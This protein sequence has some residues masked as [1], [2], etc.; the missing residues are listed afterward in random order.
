MP[1]SIRQ[2]GAVWYARGTIRIGP[3]S[4]RISEFSTGA[5]TRAAAR[6]F[7]DEHEAKI[8]REA[9][10]GDHGR[11]SR[12]TLADCFEAYI[13][14]PGGV[15]AY[16]MERIVEF[17]ERL[18]H[19]KL[20]EAG[21][22]WAEFL[23]TRGAKMAPATASRWRAIY[24]AAIKVGAEA[25]DAP[26]PNV[27]AVRD[28]T[29]QVLRTL[30]EQERSDLLAAYGEAASPVFLTLAYQGLRT[31]EALRLDWRNVHWARS[32]SL[33]ISRSKSGKP[34]SVPM[35]T[36]VRARLY[37]LWESA[38]KPDSGPVFLSGRKAPEARGEIDPTLTQ[39]DRKAANK[40]LPNIPYADTRGKGG[41]PLR[42]AHQLACK[43]AGV[44]DFRIHDWRHDWASRMVMAGVDLFTLMKLGGW[45][46]LRMVEIYGSSTSEHM[47]SAVQKIV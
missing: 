6:S 38:G 43:K 16:D 3:E 23:S 36:K 41:N 11:R 8:R 22:A 4:I 19:R 25:N 30:T 26:I 42:S 35:H 37:L 14:R 13:G 28:K 10:E 45:S 2:R 39:R 21:N 1:L 31:S 32:G 15:P 40:A 33:Y 24:M 12:L 47:A 9:L 44:R 18:G 7:A 17:N 27:P 29:E 5:R 46:T 20:T 34:R